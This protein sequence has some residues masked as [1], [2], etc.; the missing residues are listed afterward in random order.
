M[1][2][3][4]S[5]V[6][7]WVA[8]QIANNVEACGATCFLDRADIEHGDDFE[9][10]IVKAADASHELLVLFTPWAK[11]SRYIWVEMGMFKRDKKRVVGVL[12]GVKASE[13]AADDRI[14]VLLKRIDLVDLNDIDSYF[15][16]LRRRVSGRRP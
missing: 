5:S 1:F 9:D 7:T 4:H 11:D 13:I 14:P 3:S 6:D 12:H 10:E 16:Q 2:I 15:K 8:R